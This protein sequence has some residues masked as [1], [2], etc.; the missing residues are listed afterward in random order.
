M[1]SP[2]PP[3]PANALPYEPTPEYTP[4]VGVIH[5]P[6]LPG[7]PGYQALSVAEIIDQARYDAH[8]YREAGLNCLI[9]ENM[10]DVPYLRGGV[11]PE[12]VAM[13]S[14]VALA[15]RSD[16][17]LPLGVQI[18]AGANQEAVAVAHAAGLEFVRVEG[19]SYAHVADE[20]LLQG[21]AGEL[22]R[23]RR[24]IGADKVQIWADIKKKHASH[25]LTADVSLGETA[26]AA[27]FM[28]ANAVI[29]TG[30]R[31]G[32]AAALA[33]V[34]A[35]RESCG[36]PVFVGSG[37]TLMNVEEFLPNCDGLIVGSH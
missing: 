27:E 16:C 29:V 6:A 30:N 31:T 20:G 7:T 14:V 22:L 1:S 12:I 3:P 33:D 37:V 32:H 17:S 19:F 2:L 24:Q 21:C 34:R 10:H 35:A 36:L 8:L 5:L 28:R 4:V 25:A 13:M 23:Y 15:V 18:L 9:L 26:A 11:G